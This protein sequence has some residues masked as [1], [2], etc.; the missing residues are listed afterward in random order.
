MDVT[1]IVKDNS[2]TNSG[3]APWASN[4]AWKAWMVL[5]WVSNMG[6]TQRGG[7]AWYHTRTSTSTLEP[8]GRSA[9]MSYVTRSLP[10]PAFSVKSASD[11]ACPST[12]VVSYTG[13]SNEKPNGNNRLS[14]AEPAARSSTL[15][16]A[17]VTS[18]ATSS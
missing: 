5:S 3:A 15:V 10:A 7:I 16:G 9:T 18:T 4:R 11:S 2:V 17:P 6:L 12:L 14:F 1:G 13:W 8:N